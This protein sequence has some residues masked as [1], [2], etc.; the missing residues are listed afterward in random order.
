VAIS[1]VFTPFPWQVPAWQDKGGTLLLTGAA[2]GGKSRLAAEKWH[3]FLLRYP[4]ATG[5][6]GR[7]DKTAAMKSVVPFLQYT[8]Q[9][10]T[11]WGKYHKSEGLFEYING[12][13]GWVVGMRDEGQRE[14]LRSIGKDGSVDIAWFEEANKLTMADDAEVTARMRGNAA[15]W[16]QKIYSTNPDGP[17]HWIKKRLID[18]KLASVYYSRPEDNPTNPEDYILGLQSLSGLYYQRLYKGLWVQAEGAIYPTYNSAIHLLDRNIATPVTG[19]YIVSVDFG[20]TAPF[21]CT[22]W[23]IHDNKIY[24]VKQI[25]RTKTLVEEHA[26]AIRTMLAGLDIA[27]HKVEAW[28]CDHDAEGRAT[29]E[30]H[31]GITTKPAYKAIKEG[32]EAVGARWKNNTLFLNQW[33]VDEPDPELERAY[34]P[35]STADE[36]PGYVW[37]DK[38]QD[39]PIGEHDHGCDEMRYLVAYVDKIGS[40]LVKVGTSKARITNYI[41]GKTVSPMPQ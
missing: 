9:G 10:D 29:L 36:V 24:Q 31:L 26:V 23:R 11:G 7:K 16:R 5:I 17:E 38:K 4:G 21:S 12:S 1:K 20:Y 19:R 39:T 3:G 40:Q 33:A 25:Y 18:A 34:L 32:I 27:L 6:V 35:L 37:S 14:N 30:K 28:V 8:V 2:G 15:G 22:V 13:Q 41:S